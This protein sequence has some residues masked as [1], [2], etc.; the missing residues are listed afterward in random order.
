ME[1]EALRAA[2]CQVL[3]KEVREL[4][5][6]SVFVVLPVAVALGEALAR[7][8]EEPARRALRHGKGKA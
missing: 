5:W 1:G 4:P 3:I 6:W 8:V 7:W 2:Q